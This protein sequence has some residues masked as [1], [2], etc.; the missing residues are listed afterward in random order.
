MGW[1]ELEKLTEEQAPRRK[2][3]L[4]P[5]K[6]TGREEQERVELAAK[7]LNVGLHRHEIKYVLGHRFAMNGQRVRQYIAK[8]QTLLREATGQTA[9]ALQRGAAQHYLL[10]AM[11]MKLQ[12]RERTNAWVRLVELLGLDQAIGLRQELEKMD[13]AAKAAR[14]AAPGPASG[15]PPAG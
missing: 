7:L 9:E 5:R 13:A 15:A 4:S 11:N 14:A 10:V 3:G 1:D 12:P 2:T 6:V 8:A